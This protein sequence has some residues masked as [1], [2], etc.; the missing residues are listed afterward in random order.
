MNKLIFILL[1]AGGY[2]LITNQA[3]AALPTLDDAIS[4]IPKPVTIFFQ[5]LQNFD[6]RKQAGNSDIA[7]NLPVASKPIVNFLN[8]IWA[9]F[10][11]FLKGIGS[12]FVW[13]FHGIAG[14]LDALIFTR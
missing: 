2:L 7:K 1:I 9:I 12:I 6:F 5:S 3:S 11:G 8:F 10:Y 13:I 4:I 14:L